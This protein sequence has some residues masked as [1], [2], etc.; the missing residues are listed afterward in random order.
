MTDMFSRAERS[1]NM[2]KI[3]AK[4]T[5]PEM[6]VR[7]YLFSEGFRYRLHAKKLPGNPDIVLPKY[8]TIVF[9]NGCFWHQHENC[10]RSN[11]PKTNTD[12]WVPKLKRNIE[13]QKNIIKELEALG[14]KVLIVWECGLKKKDI[15]VQSPG[16]KKAIIG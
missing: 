12:Y 7:K 14:W 6:I 9:V 8:K 2:S 4:N 3:R 13:R 15:S 1:S 10:R 11:S 16:L 5:K